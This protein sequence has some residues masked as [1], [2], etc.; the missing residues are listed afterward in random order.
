MGQR[1]KK[2]R[3]PHMDL[4]AT[5]K[6]SLLSLPL[7]GS[8]LCISDEIAFFF[9][10]NLICLGE[11]AQ[12]AASWNTL[13]WFCF[14]STILRATKFDLIISVTLENHTNL[15]GVKPRQFYCARR[16]GGWR[17]GEEHSRDGSSLL[18]LNLYWLD[19]NDWGLGGALLKCFLCSCVW[20]LSWDHLKAGLSGIVDW[21]TSIWSLWASLVAQW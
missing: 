10:L 18:H 8:R 21:N 19:L 4:G 11:T 16:F 1:K 15:G 7:D 13:V 5:W 20:C 3:N 6:D 9:S 14:H 2:H 17:I 12:E